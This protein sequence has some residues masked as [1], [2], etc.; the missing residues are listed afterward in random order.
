MRPLVSVCT[1][2]FN[3]RRTVKR[4]IESVV[5]ALKKLNVDF[6]VIVVDNYSFDGTHEKLLELKKELKRQGIHMV[7]LRRKCTRG[8]GRQLAYKLSKGA[9][10]LTIDCDEIYNSNIL[11]SIIGWY[12]DSELRDKV[13][14]FFKQGGLFPRSLLGRVGGWRNLNYLEFEDLFLRLHRIGKLV[15]IPAAVSINEPYEGDRE[16][17][18][19]RKT[20]L[21]YFYRKLINRVSISVGEG[22]TLNHLCKWILKSRYF[23]K[24]PALRTIFTSL[25][26]IFASLLG[27]MLLRAKPISYNKFLS[28]THFLMVLDVLSMLRYVKHLQELKMRYKLKYN[29]RFSENRHLK[30]ISLFCPSLRNIFG[31]ILKSLNNYNEN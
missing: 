25:L 11:K 3:N 30:Y 23:Y 14:V 31:I 5:E 27:L 28:N 18:Y 12:M 8:L 29:F 21:S 4:S 15:K 17:R 26:Q 16:V 9:I 22:Y 13:A 24:K 6:E 1:T 2:V 7:I 19:V 20:S 10:I